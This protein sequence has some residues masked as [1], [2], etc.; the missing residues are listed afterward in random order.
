M[1]TIAVVRSQTEIALHIG[2][3]RADAGDPL[4]FA[5]E[6]L[7]MF[8]DREHVGEFLLPDV[9]LQEWSPIPDLDAECRGYLD[10]AMGKAGGHRGI[11]AGR[12]VEKLTQYAWLAGREDVVDAMRAAPYPN[13]GVPKLEVFARGMGL[14]ETWEAGLTDNL[15]AMARGESCSPNC[16][17]CNS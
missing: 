14:D 4:G 10:L 17:G 3:V 16:R 13:Y 1:T 7:I 12:S 9:D 5:S 15:R 8:L 11:S 6:A 2:A